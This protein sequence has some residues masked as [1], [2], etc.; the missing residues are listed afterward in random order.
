MS[1]NKILE[2]HHF[3]TGDFLL[4]SYA[5]KLYRWLIKLSLNHTHV[6][7]IIHNPPW[8]KDLKGYYLLQ[9]NREA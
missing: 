2:K 8:R 9:S 3:E 7:M 1:L 5:G 4:F 6:G